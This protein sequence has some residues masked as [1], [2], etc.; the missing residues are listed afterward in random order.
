MEEKTH[1]ELK[2]ATKE[3]ISKRKI[4]WSPKSEEIRTIGKRTNSHIRA[5]S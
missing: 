1:G 2:R 5:D 4:S 3:N